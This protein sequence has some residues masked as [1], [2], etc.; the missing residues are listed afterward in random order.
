[1]KIIPAIEKNS[2]IEYPKEIPA[3]VQRI[4]FNGT[5]WEIAETK[6]EEDQI[7]ESCPSLKVIVDE[8]KFPKPIDVV[9][10]EAE[11]ISP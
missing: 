10:E 4:H 2:V 6:Q 8:Q 3:G 1:M 7:V 5:S 11:S 9:A